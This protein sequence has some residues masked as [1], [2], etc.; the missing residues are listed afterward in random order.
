VIAIVIGSIVRAHWLSCGL[1]ARIFHPH[2]DGLPI[3]VWPSLGYDGTDRAIA[4]KQT[5]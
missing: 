4:E 5:F 2:D 1:P 3:L